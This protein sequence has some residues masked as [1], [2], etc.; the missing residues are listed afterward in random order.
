MKTKNLENTYKKQEKRS[1]SPAVEQAGRI[2]FCL[3]KSTSMQMG[4]MEIA[5]EVGV[6]GSKAYGILEALQQSG[7][8]KRGSDGKGYSLAQGVVTLS[9][10]FLDDLVPSKLAEYV[11]EKLTRDTDRTSVFGV[12][13]D[14][15]VTI[16][17]KHNRE[18]NMITI[19]IPVGR[20]MPLTQGA[21]G[22][23][24]VAFLPEEEREII[25]A[26]DKL[27]FH[28]NPDKLDRRRLIKELEQ[29]RK[30]GFACD[31]EE[32]VEGI[33]IVA[34]PVI[35]PAGMPIGFVGIFDLSSA[36]R[37]RELGPVVAEAGR[38]L[39]RKLGADI[40]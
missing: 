34:A 27:N 17:A 6:S 18:G 22:K 30:D 13:M 10:K 16:A 40:D 19:G 29:C 39:S 12:I 4:L 15:I 5:G 20:I 9:R 37:A 25:L 35:S 11:L 36:K 3:A 38:S 8:V 1:S 2:L 28:G 23:A 32:S 31:M 7:L 24:I 21:H 26:N 14:D 33:N